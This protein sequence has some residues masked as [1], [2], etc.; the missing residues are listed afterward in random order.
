MRAAAAEWRKVDP[1]KAS[2]EQRARM[3]KAVAAFE[4]EVVALRR[5]LEG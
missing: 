4:A 2:R 1:K 3:E 5:E